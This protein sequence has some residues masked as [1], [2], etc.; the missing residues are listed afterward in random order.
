MALRPP[1]LDR[2]AHAGLRARWTGCPG[3]VP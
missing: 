2:A 3:S 1:A